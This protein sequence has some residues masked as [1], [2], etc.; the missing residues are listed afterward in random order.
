MQL[1]ALA[2]ACALGAALLGAGVGMNDAQARGYDAYYQVVGVHGH[3]T[4]KLRRRPHFDAPIVHRLGFNAVRIAHDGPRRRG[5]QRVYA[6]GV[7]GWVPIRHL[8]EDVHVKRTL[9][10]VT[11]LEARAVLTLHSKPRRRSR[12]LID[13]PAHAHGILACGDCK[14]GWCPVRYRGVDGWVRKR[15]LTV[16]ADE[17]DIDDRRY[18]DRRGDGRYE[19]FDRYD[20]SDVRYDRYADR[21]DRYHRVDQHDVRVRPLYYD[22]R[23]SGQRSYDLDDDARYLADPDYVPYK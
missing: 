23:V 11:G 21:R 16:H 14:R 7:R 19:R 17:I 8:A 22:R 9:Y 12:I 4:L 13:I 18:S 5:W 15:F 20:R 2:S 3:E 10:A 6:E 1:S